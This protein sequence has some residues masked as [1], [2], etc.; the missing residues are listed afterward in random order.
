MPSRYDVN[1][2]QLKLSAE[3]IARAR[4]TE[5][6]G[7]PAIFFECVGSTNAVACQQA[8]TGAAE[9]LLVVADEQTAGRGRM[10][11]SWW[12]PKGAGLLFS[13]LLRPVIPAARAGQ[14]SMCLGLGTAEGIESVT[15]LRPALKWPNDLLLGGRKLGGML[16]ELGV[17][18]NRVEYVVLGLGVNVNG[19]PTDLAATS[20]SLSA[21]LDRAVDRVELLAEILAHF[22]AWYERLLPSAAEAGSRKLGVS[23]PIHTAW[24]A[25]LDTLGR[26]VT[27]TTAAGQRRGK[28]VG[29]SPEGALLLQG[30]DGEIT[31]IWSG[32]VTSRVLHLGN[33][34]CDVL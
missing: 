16:S 25:R 32:D 5:R 6:L 8:A 19:V 12:A 27:V 7:Q 10:G 34:A 9:G 29:V 30:E 33:S 4:R 2:D 18:E 24:A 13:L 22:E 21:V 31:M 11:R 1:E 15:G 26:D 28:A 3:A 23:D 20:I 14:L 17:A